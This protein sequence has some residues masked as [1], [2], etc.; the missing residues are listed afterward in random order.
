MDYRREIYAIHKSWRRNAEFI[1]MQK[2]MRKV[3]AKGNQ[4]L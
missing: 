4:M 3:H 2:A 1:S